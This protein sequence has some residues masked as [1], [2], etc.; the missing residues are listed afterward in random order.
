M[1]KISF[2]LCILASLSF[3]A[4]SIA[5]DDPSVDEILALGERSREE[6]LDEQLEKTRELVYNSMMSDNDTYL[7]P[8][9]DAAE[10]R[11]KKI[12]TDIYINDLVDIMKE[13]KVDPSK[14]LTIMELKVFYTYAKARRIELAQEVDTSGNVIGMIVI[15]DA[16]KLSLIHI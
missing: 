6:I 13:L 5:G 3:S 2:L 10:E 8:L 7:F 15:V 9:K 4:L 12:N 1:K 16:A 11:R 14:E